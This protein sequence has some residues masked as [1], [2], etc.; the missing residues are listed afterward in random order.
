MPHIRFNLFL[1]GTIFLSLLFFYITSYASGFEVL[2]SNYA[3]FYHT[4]AKVK[5]WLKSSKNSIE[6]DI[7]IQDYHLPSK[8]RKFKYKIPVKILNSFYSNKKYIYLYIEANK[9]QHFKLIFSG[10]KKAEILINGAK[11]GKI[12]LKTPFNYSLA[13]I[14]LKSGVYFILIE[15][16][17][18]FKNIPVLILSNKKLTLSKKRGFT[19]SS[20]S[21]ATIYNI[22]KNISIKKDFFGKF[23]KGFCFPSKEEKNNFF[24]HKKIDLSNKQKQ[25]PL[26]QALFFS[27]SKKYRNILHSLGF[28]NKALDWWKESFRKKRI[29]SYG[30]ESF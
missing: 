1:R 14:S 10:I 15:I 18:F 9:S 22:S 25:T 16:D 6:K 5:K 12:D 28:N 19:L 17:K 26:I 8:Y 20:Y 2:K 13:N 23:Y 30:K 3:F 7:F 29:C 4:P 24:F 11:R 27:C 21:S